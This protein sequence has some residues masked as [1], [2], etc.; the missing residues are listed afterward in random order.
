MAAAGAAYIGISYVAAIAVHPPLAVILLGLVPLGVVALVSAWHSQ[1]R[2]L[3]LSLCAAGALA[4]ILNLENLRN[5]A[6]WLYFIQHA[7][8]MIL[9]C[10]TFGGT[11][12]RSH[13]DALCSR[14]AGFIL[15]KPMDADYLHYTWKV[16]LYWAVFFAVSAIVSVLLFFFGSIEVWSFFA[17]LLTP[18]LLG[19][20]FAGEYL[21][22]M[23][24]LPDRAHFNVIETIQAY[25]EYSH[26]QKSG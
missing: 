23:R 11:L 2:T 15:G 12:W 4:V 3:S 19:V 22:R 7:G 17:N 16:T 14:V 18:I 13:A 24:V 25:R 5:H 10:M 6:A 1:T 20:M 8:A 9:L 21:I 26:R